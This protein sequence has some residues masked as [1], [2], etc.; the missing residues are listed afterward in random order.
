MTIINSDTAKHSPLPFKMPVKLVATNLLGE[1]HILDAEGNYVMQV[2]NSE[3]KTCQ[4]FV[5]VC[6]SFKPMKEA[7]ENLLFECQFNKVGA[8]WIE[9]AKSAL[10]LAESNEHTKQEGN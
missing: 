4:A 8:H 10:A 9:Q 7:L 6:N 2:M 3:V 5:R 1:L